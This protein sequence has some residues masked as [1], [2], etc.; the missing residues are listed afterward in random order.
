MT[1]ELDLLSEEIKIQTDIAEGLR[2]RMAVQDNCYQHHKIIC[3]NSTIKRLKALEAL[4]RR[5]WGGAA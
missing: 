2:V 3:V 1:L 4:E 5:Q